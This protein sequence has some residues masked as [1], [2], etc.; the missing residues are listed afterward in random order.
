MQLPNTTAFNTQTEGYKCI[1]NN[2]L[3]AFEGGIGKVLNSGRFLICLI[4]ICCG[5]LQLYSSDTYF[6]RHPHQF[7][8]YDEILRNLLL[9]ISCAKGFIH[10]LQEILSPELDICQDLRGGSKRTDLGISV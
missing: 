3:L 10:Q 7:A 1:Q 4:I 6:C 2:L 8:F 5:E 9:L